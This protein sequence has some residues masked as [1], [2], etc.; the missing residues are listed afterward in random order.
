MGRYSKLIFGRDKLPARCIIYAGAY[1]PSRKKIVWRHFDKW[2]RVKGYWVR[3]VYAQKNGRE[4]LILFNV[5][6]GAF[7]MEALHILR[8]GGVRNTFFIGS[9]GGKYL[10][11]GTIILPIEVIERSGPVIIDNTEVESIKCSREIVD[12]LAKKMNEMGINY[13]KGKIMSV[14]CVLHE[15]KHLRKMF[16]DRDDILGVEMEL[17]SY[18]YY[19]RKL[20]I[21]AFALIYISDNKYYDVISRREE[22]VKAR[23]RALNTITKIALNTI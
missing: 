6:G 16:E 4:Y 7:M 14:P 23:K 17:A 20:G 5:Y 22:A 21:K 13:T 18:I 12:F 8:D 9:A 11:I 1:L 19:A 3:Y 10:P 2:G 15:I